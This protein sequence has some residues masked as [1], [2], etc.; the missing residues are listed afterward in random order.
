[1]LIYVHDPRPHALVLSQ[2]DIVVGTPGRLNDLLDDGTLR[3]DEVETVVLDEVFSSSFRLFHMFH[4]LFLFFKCFFCFFP[5]CVS[6][7]ALAT[8]VPSLCACDLQALVAHL[9]L[10][11]YPLPML[12]N[13]STLCIP[14]A[15][16]PVHDCDKLVLS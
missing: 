6:I 14:S 16:A 7:S 13:P 5:K 10:H 9:S 15:R 11:A 1:M 2:V 4:L 12:P 3:L 8:R